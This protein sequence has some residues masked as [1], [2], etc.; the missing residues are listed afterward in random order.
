MKQCLVKGDGH[1]GDCVFTLLKP[2][3]AAAQDKRKERDNQLTR[4][5]IA[6]GFIPTLL[7]V[8]L[9]EGARPSDYASAIENVVGGALDI[10]DALIAK[11]GGYGP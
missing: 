11:T 2:E 8:Q 7:S 3:V 1:A 6:Q 10:A 4:R 5:Q 9:P